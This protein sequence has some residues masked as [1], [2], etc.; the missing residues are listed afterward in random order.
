LSG[1][2]D[3]ILIC[4]GNRSAVQM[5]KKAGGVS[6]TVSGGTVSYSG[7]VANQFYKE[8]LVESAKSCGARTVNTDRLRVGQ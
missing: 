3:Q 2:D 8:R 7:S 5:I 1:S 6:Y 4:I